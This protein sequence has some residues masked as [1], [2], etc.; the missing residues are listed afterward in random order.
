MT[1][2]KLSTDQL[3]ELGHRCVD[4]MYHHAEKDGWDAMRYG[5][6]W[7]TARINYPRQCGVFDRLKAEWKRRQPAMP[8]YGMPA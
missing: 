7:P 1:L 2:A 3:A 8:R 6:D 4:K 5:L